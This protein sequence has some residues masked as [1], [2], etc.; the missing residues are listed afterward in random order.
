MATPSTE[1][2]IAASALAYGE[3][4]S[5]ATL[6]AL[7]DQAEPSDPSLTT[8][9]PLLISPQADEADGMYADAFL[10]GTGQIVI[11]F[12]GTKPTNTSSQVLGADLSIYNQKIPQ[13]FLDAKA[14]AATVASAAAARGIP[15]TQI[16]VTGHSLGGSEAEYIASLPQFGYGG[17]TFGATGIPG[18]VNS[19]PQPALVDYV[20][21]G[22]PI[23]NY[24]SDTKAAEPGF[25]P[26]SNMDHV[27]TLVP[28]GS[29]IDGYALA[30][31]SIAAHLGNQIGDFIASDLGVGGL[32]FRRPHYV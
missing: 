6:L 21:R 29:T 26:A 9:T 13:A 30:A 28:V 16:F 27:G 1:D 19:G 12:E 2:F 4:S 25:A 10:T 5:L 11:A 31:S 23:G 22:D 7:V 3:A 20:D 32:A 18:Y 15:A 14:F 24:A 17:A 8:W